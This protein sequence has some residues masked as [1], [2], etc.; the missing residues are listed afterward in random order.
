MLSPVSSPQNVCFSLVQG[1]GLSHGSFIS[2][3]Q[4]GVEVRLPAPSCIH[5]LPLP[6]ASNNPPAKVA[7][8]GVARCVALPILNVVYMVLLWVGKVVRSLCLSIHG[9]TVLCKPALLL[10]NHVVGGLTLVKGFRSELAVPLAIQFPPEFR[11]LLIPLFPARPT[12]QCAFHVLSHEILTPCLFHFLSHP[13]CYLGTT[14]AVGGADDTL[15]RT[16]LFLF[17]W[18]FFWFLIFLVFLKHIP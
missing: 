11:K 13:K 6:V 12:G 10:S 15:I 5:R 1:E 17:I 9:M 4:R 7:Y 14:E 2:W 3:K 18:E 8:F 16:L